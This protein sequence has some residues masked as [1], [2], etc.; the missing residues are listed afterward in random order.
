MTPSEL[1]GWRK[2]RGLSQAALAALLDISKSRLQDYERGATR[3][4]ETPAPIPRLVELA[5]ETLARKHKLAAQAA[6]YKV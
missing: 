1:I 5:L 6:G 2:Q 3:V 4:R